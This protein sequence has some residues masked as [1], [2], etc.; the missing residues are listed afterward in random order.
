MENSRERL[1]LLLPPAQGCTASPE[2][3]HGAIVMNANPFTRWGI[4]G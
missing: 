2:K 1:D 3:N 4:A